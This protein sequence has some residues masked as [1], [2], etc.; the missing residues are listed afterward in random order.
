MSHIGTQVA[1]S[2]HVMKVSHG[3]TRR[4]V[5][6]IAGIVGS[7]VLAS[8]LA[9][10]SAY[11]GLSSLADGS[12]NSAD[13]NG[14]IC[15]I[16]RESSD[17]G[18]GN[19]DFS[20][21][22]C[23]G[24]GGSGSAGGGSSGGGSGSAGGGGGGGGS[25]SAG[26]GSSGGRSANAGGESSS[27]SGSH[28]GYGDS[29]SGG[30]SWDFGFGSDGPRIDGG[31]SSSGGGVACFLAGTKILTANFERTVEDLRAGDKLPTVSGHT[32]A[33][34]K[35][36]SWSVERRVDE[37]WSENLAPIKVCRGALGPNLPREDLYLSPMHALYLDSVLIPVGNLV[38]GSSIVRCSDYGG[39]LITY[40]HIELEDHQVIW[41]NG[42]PVES[43]LTESMTP[44]ATIWSGGRRFE[45]SSRLR[46]AISPWFDNRTTFDKIRDRIEERSEFG[47]VIA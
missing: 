33:I 6:A 11:A 18:R 5:I 20:D 19:S 42:A 41:A 22:A 12:G 24:G 28:R 38:N 17:N 4:N 45:L 47:F 30:N 9:A 31:G 36:Q 32:R 44:F 16:G 7:T 39:N 2:G 34:K 1:Q 15:D 43:L 8:T 40:F 21:H 23:Q 13:E 25:G 3:R 10:K 35:I 27:G 26:G 29:N 46:S 14:R 37:K